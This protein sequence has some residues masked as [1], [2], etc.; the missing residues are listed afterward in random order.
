M[1]TKV[2]YMDSIYFYS[3]QQVLCIYKI[4]IYILE[5]SAAVTIKF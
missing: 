3:M 4:D 5:N 1:F 2:Q